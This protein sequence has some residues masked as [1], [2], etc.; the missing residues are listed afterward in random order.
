[1]PGKSPI[2]YLI[3]GP[4]GAGKTTFAKQFLPVIGV[5]EFLNADSLRSGSGKNLCGDGSFLVKKDL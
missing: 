2:L 1:M 3:V 4:N 5:M